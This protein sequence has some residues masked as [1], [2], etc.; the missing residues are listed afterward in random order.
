[1]AKYCELLS[2]LPTRMLMMINQIDSQTYC[3]QIIKGIPEKAN[4]TTQMM[5][6]KINNNCFNFEEGIFQKGFQQALGNFHKRFT[7]LE[8]RV[9]Q[10]KD[11]RIS[12]NQLL[13]LL[14]PPISKR[15]RDQ[16][17]QASLN[18]TSMQFFL[19][20]QELYFYDTFLTLVKKCQSTFK[21]FIYDYFYV[22]QIIF[23]VFLAYQIT[24]LIFVRS[25]LINQM[26]EDIFKS[27]GILNLI[28]DSFFETNRQRVENIIKKLKD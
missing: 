12:Y 17:G 21:D 27:R 15:S 24:I 23:L 1:M 10:Q 6:E 26:Q 13:T 11:G 9:N 8:I 7:D 3:S 14:N 5:K 16:L 22:S 20:A 28:P 2:R 25:R 18:V 19:T 4:Q